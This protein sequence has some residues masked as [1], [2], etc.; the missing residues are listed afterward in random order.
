MEGGMKGGYW[1]DWEDEK[2]GGHQMRRR[3]ELNHKYGWN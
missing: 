3:V 1:S 2:G